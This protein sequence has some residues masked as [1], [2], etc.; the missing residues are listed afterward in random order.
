[1]RTLLDRSPLLFSPGTT[2]AHKSPVIGAGLL[3]PYVPPSAKCIMIQASV[4]D[5]RY[6]LDGTA[7][8]GVFG[9]MLVA[10]NDPIIIEL[11]ENIKLQ[12]FGTDATSMLNYCFGD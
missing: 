10:G 9:F 4:K 3:N 11:N 6:T 8:T 7:P 1:M 2:E 12:F 5:I